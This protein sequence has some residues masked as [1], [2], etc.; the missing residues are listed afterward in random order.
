[1]VQALLGEVCCVLASRQSRPHWQ[2]PAAPLSCDV[3]AA[4]LEDC[5]KI[6][7][8]AG[9]NLRTGPVELCLPSLSRSCWFGFM[10]LLDQCAPSPAMPSTAP[11][12]AAGSGLAAPPPLRAPRLGDL[13]RGGL[14]PL[15][16]LP[17]GGPVAPASVA[18]PM[19][20][21]ALCCQELTT[22]SL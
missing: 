21:P 18:V 15:A 16:L 7:P 1:M 20:W 3:H 4:L 10:L 9:K 5:K 22:T 14:R 8:E 19:A 6:G 17:C 12:P 11:S 2:L 13:A